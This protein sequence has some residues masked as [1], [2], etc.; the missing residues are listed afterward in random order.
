FGGI[1]ALQEDVRMRI[2]EPR[3]DRRAGEVDRFCAGGNFRRSGV[4]DSHDAT[5]LDDDHL[6]LAWLIALAVQQISRANYGDL[7]RSGA[8]GLGLCRA[9]QGKKTETDQS[10]EELRLAARTLEPHSHLLIRSHAG[11]RR[12]LNE[13]PI[14]IPRARGFSKPSSSAA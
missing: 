11:A 5:A 8:A 13:G 2:D 1:F 6:V 14:G 7:L 9:Q 3:Q 12:S 10:N 4:S